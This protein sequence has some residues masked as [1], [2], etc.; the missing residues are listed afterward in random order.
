MPYPSPVL[1][2]DLQNYL[3]DSS[4]DPD[5]IYLFEQSLNAAT[6]RVYTYLGRD[7][8]ASARTVIFWGD[9]GTRHRIAE[10]AA[11]ILSWEYRD[12]DGNVSLGDI[13]KLKLFEDGLLIIAHDVTFLPGYEHHITFMPPLTLLCPDA[14]RQVILE[15]AATI[16]EESKRGR[17][18]LVIESEWQTGTSGER[19]KELDERHEKILAP[20]RRYL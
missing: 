1:V 9:G 12:T 16:Y 7:Y 15:I 14:V 3:N 13:T 20:Y 11:T 10:E 5:I 8:T 6:D 19:Y 17:G 4:T 18:I 2:S